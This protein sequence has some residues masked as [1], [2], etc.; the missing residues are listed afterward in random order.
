MTSR[1]RLRIALPKCAELPAIC[2]QFRACG[3]PV[4]DLSTAGL[5]LIK[6]PINCGFDFEI[7]RLA[8]PD[9][10]TYVEHAISHVGIMGTDLLRESDAEV[11]R[12]L[13]FPYGKY[14][15]VFA[16]PRGESIASLSAR[17]QIRIATPYPRYTR[18]LFAHRGLAAEI[19]AVSDSTTACLL[20]LADGYV[21]R[22]TDPQS[23][24]DHDF[25]VVELLGYTRLKLIV[26]RACWA[27]RRIAIQLLVQRLELHQPLPPA[28]IF[29]P[30][31]DEDDLQLVRPWEGESEAS[32]GSD[33]AEDSVG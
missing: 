20:G 29:I 11:W 6:D 10:G 25:R 24:L 8:A 27:R 32:E 26:N 28:E 16:A 31:D 7:F 21:D 12:P 15:L 19:V 2:E 1:D 18:E 23:L 4:P 9:V 13:T 14:P 5:H 33:E 30:F 3:F 22:L 17:P